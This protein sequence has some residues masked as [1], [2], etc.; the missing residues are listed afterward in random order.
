[1]SEGSCCKRI[2]SGRGSSHGCSRRGTVVIGEKRYCN[3]HS[4]LAEEV[5]RAERD[6]RVAARIIREGCKWERLHLE[7]SAIDL[8]RAITKGEA[9]PAE[10]E[11]HVARWDALAP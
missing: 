1:M 4:P 11:Q 7:R 6:K 10:A 9:G 3:Q 8:L 5:R 2:F